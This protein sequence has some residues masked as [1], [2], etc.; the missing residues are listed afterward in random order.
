MGGNIKGVSAAVR[1]SGWV[2][3]DYV[4]G[5]A[6]WVTAGW[7][8]RRGKGSNIWFLMPL[9]SY[10]LWKQDWQYLHKIFNLEHVDLTLFIHLSPRDIHFL[11]H[12]TEIDAFEAELESRISWRFVVY[13]E[14]GDW[15]RTLQTSED[16]RLILEFADLDAFRFNALILWQH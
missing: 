4:Q 13:A 7:G 10:N 11:V 6:P 8:N 12:D 1:G 9:G 2:R 5:T 16:Q 14:D 3:C 15:A